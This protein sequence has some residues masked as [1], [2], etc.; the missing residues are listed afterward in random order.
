M[1][2]SNEKFSRKLYSC[3]LKWILYSR[4]TELWH[5]CFSKRCT[6]RKRNQRRGSKYLSS[7]YHHHSLLE[8]PPFIMVERSLAYAPLPIA[9]LTTAKSRPACPTFRDSLGLSPRGT[10]GWQLTPVWQCAVLCHCW[11][12]RERAGLPLLGRRDAFVLFLLSRSSSLSL[13]LSCPLL[14]SV[15][16]EY[17]A[18][19]SLSF[20]LFTHEKNFFLSFSL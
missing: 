8:H 3:E 18:F 10:T 12:P 9:R 14:W 11:E 15:R 7:R 2:Y 20:F 5:R 4:L 19:C 16:Y 6:L 17:N 13:S 1:Y